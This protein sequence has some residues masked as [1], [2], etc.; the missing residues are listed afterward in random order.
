MFPER[1]VWPA[2]SG[3]RYRA[4]R[5]SRPQMSPSVVLVDHVTPPP[6]VGPGQFQLLT[7]RRPSGGQ[8]PSTFEP[9][10]AYRATALSAVYGMALDSCGRHLRNGLAD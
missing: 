4:W 8:S 5:Q 6:A 1:V 9:V 7:A 3:G 2:W 10:G